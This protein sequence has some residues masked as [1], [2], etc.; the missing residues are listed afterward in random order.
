LIS[1]LHPR[2]E[3]PNRWK[4]LDR[5]IRGMTAAAASRDTRRKYR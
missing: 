4:L 3:C 1:D 5:E 2:A